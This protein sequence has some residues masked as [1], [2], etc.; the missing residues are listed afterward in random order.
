MLYEIIHPLSTTNAIRIKLEQ[1]NGKRIVSPISAI[2]YSDLITKLSKI[3]EEL[4]GLVNKI[5]EED[6]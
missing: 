5:K 6:R 2:R 1:L 4:T 3:S